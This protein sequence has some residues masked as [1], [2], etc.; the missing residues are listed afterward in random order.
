MTRPASAMTWSTR[1]RLPGWWTVSIIRISGIFTLRLP[2]TGASP[3]HGNDRRAG[4]PRPFGR[5]GSEGP[6]NGGT[7]TVW[8]ARVPAAFAISLGGHP[9]RITKSAITLAALAVGF[10]G[11][12]G[13]AS[14]K[15]PA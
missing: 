4:T 2:A 12:A 15:E 13:C 8:P 1:A 11:L 10:L 5:G 3:L 7:L 14:Q 9:M 6:L